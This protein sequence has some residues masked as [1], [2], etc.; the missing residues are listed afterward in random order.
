MQVFLLYLS[1]VLIWGS[2]WFVITF[3]L[4]KVAADVSV[5]YRFALAMLIFVAITI[6]RGKFNLLKFSPRD[7][8][9][10]AIQGIFLFCLNYWIFYIAT[11]YLTSGLVAISFSTII[12]M[13][14]FN[15]AIF[16][17]KR[18]E[19]KTIIAASMGLVGIGLVFYPEI[20]ILSFESDILW[21]LTL[22][23]IATFFASLGN[24][25]SIRNSNANLPLMQVNALGMGYGAIVIFAIAAF[26][27]SEFII[28]TSF[29]YI[30]SLACLVIFGSIIAFGCYLTL[31]AKIGADKGAYAAVF[32]PIVALIISTIFENYIWTMDAMIGVIFIVSGNIIILLPK[33]NIFKTRAI[34][35]K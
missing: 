4:G 17:K 18:V 31:L 29:D 26:N 32:F 16:F 15:Q 30:W 14:I 3:Q 6:M 24:M 27:G 19:L 34:N 20:E 9:F 33:F 12:I 21:G 28:D 35:V 10:I 8:I 13:N 23:L 2:T 11:G 1:T 22:C 25:A 5:G 7:H